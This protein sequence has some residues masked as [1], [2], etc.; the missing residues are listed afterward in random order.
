MTNFAEEFERPSKKDF[1]R[2][3]GISKGSAG[4]VRSLLYVAQ[5]VGYINSEIRLD[6]DQQLEELAKGIGDSHDT[7]NPQAP[8]CIS[9]RNPP[10]II[11]PVTLDI[12]SVYYKL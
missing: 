8:N 9:I 3:L 2:F 11:L 12:K 4:E 7:C 1:S 6:I 10:F 5:D